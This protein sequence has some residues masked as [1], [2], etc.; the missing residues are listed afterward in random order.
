MIFNNL[1]IF[2]ILLNLFIF[3]IKKVSISFLL[4]FKI[5][6]FNRNDKSNI[7]NNAISVL[8]GIFLFCTICNSILLLPSFIFFISNSSVN[9]YQYVVT[10]NNLLKLLVIIVSLIGL[11]DFFNI[12][13]IFINSNNKVINEYDKYLLVSLFIS[14][15]L[16]LLVSPK[17]ISSGIHY[18][19]G[20]YHLPFINH[21]SK[22]SIEPGLVNLHFRYGFYG[23]SFFGQVPFQILSKDSNFLSPS[24]NIGYFAIY[25]SY[26]L[27]YLKDIRLIHIKKLI[28]KKIIFLEKIE[29]ISILYFC[30]SIIFFTGGIFKSLSSYSLDLPLFICGSIGFHLLFLSFFDKNKY[31]YFVPIF[32]LTFFSPIIKLSGVTILL[33]FCSLLFFNFAR[34]L[35]FEY[36]KNKLSN[37]FK[38]IFKTLNK[39]FVFIYNL[40]SVVNYR[41]SLTLII[42]SILVFVLTNLVITGYPLFPFELPGSFHNYSIDLEILQ[43]LKIGHLNW[44]RFQNS[45]DNSK[46]WYFAYLS[47]R[48]GLINI[49]F[50]FIPCTL[51]LLITTFIN[52]FYS[53]KKFR[54]NIN[55]LLFSITLVIIISFFKLIPVVNYYPWIPSCMIFL[56][57]ILV[58][59]LLIIKNI[60]INFPK[61]TFSILLIFIILNSFF[62]YSNSLI[63]KK[64]PSSIIKEP[65]L[66]MPKYETFDLVPK[67]WVSFGDIKS[68]NPDV[69]SIPIDGDQC[70]GIIPPCTS[71]KDLLKY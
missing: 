45:T 51:S 54:I 29:P 42:I 12:T 28:N 10:I 68:S 32:W 61:L 69:I 20:L 64:I 14:S 5:L 21:L 9:I 47:S 58:N 62:S 36:K 40:R 11:K 56:T 48:N 38:L 15:L 18:D 50:W 53:H 8:I 59:R 67:N 4:G 3:G 24:L 19:T 23:L 39:F 65:I 26:F 49:L 71:S 22:Y 66:K 27:P 55:N 60:K 1:F 30:L 57:L 25:L 46:D 63:I 44:H 70:W 7:K 31:V 37:I 33:F 41:L 52:K 34:S 35:I 13:K 16:Y 17:A 6:P 2:L 43:N